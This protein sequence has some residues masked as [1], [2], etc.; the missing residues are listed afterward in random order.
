M[1]NGLKFTTKVTLAASILLVVVLGLF[2]LNNF[3]VMRAQTHEQLN[4]VL[5][6][7][8]QS[9]SRNISNWLNAKLDIVRSVANGHDVQDSKEDILRRIKTAD[10]AGD[11]KNVYIGKRDGTFV[12]DDQSIVL[13]ADYDATTRPWFQLAK[14]KKA[15]AFTS[16]YV[17]VTTNDFTITAVV[18]ILDGSEFNGVAGGDIDMSVISKIVNEI[19]FLGYGYAFLV[20]KDRLILS[21]PKKEFNTKSLSDLFGQSLPLNSEFAEIDV[22]GTTKLVSFNKINGIKNVDWYL[23]VVINKEIAY[24]SVSATRNMAAIYMVIGVFAVIVMMQLLLKYLMAPM[25][26]LN[27][28]IKDIAQGEGDL[29]RRLDVVHNDEFG[30][31]SG[32]FNVFIEKIQ[33]S[34]AQVKDSTIELERS[35]SSLVSQTKSTLDIYD[36]QVKRTDSVATAINELSSSAVEISNNA[37]HASSL[38]SEANKLSIASQET[39]FANIRSIE[40]LSSKMQ[41]AQ[42]TVDSLDKH[43]ASIGQVLEVIRG[44]SEQTN[45]LALNAAIEAAR[46]GEAGRGFAVVADEVRQLAQRTQESTQEIQNTIAQLQQGSTVTVSVM[47]SSIE[48]SAKTV[49]Q[50]TQAGERMQEVS[51]SIDAID[52]VNHAV[53]SAT[54]QQNSVIHSLDSDIHSISDMSIHGKENLQNTLYECTNIKKQFEELERMVLKFKV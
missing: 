29:T 30:E 42:Q 17:D 1:L 6:E 4:S 34:I 43:T 3:F 39:L 20:D 47:K 10:I 8:S 13:P 5:S 51:N 31:L 35:V 2:T 48:D 50:A 9:V 19:D 7:I 23:G 46:A 25:R 40:Q 14:D 22:D 52:G 18:P 21:H 12:L 15:D 54:Q 53:A 49:L 26:H 37:H 32:Y 11:F 24:S 44:V 38:A 33:Q 41:E 16:P 28:A 36:D 45:L 27:E